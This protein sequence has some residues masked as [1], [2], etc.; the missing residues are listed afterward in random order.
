WLVEGTQ[1][2]RPLQPQIHFENS[3][4]DGFTLRPATR[5][6]LQ[7][8]FTEAAQRF[9][10]GDTLF[11]Y[12]TDHGTK[13]ADDLTNNRITLWGEKEA[14]SVNEL[15]EMLARFDPQV[16]VVVLM[17]QCF[18][19]SFA[20][21]MDNGPRKK[22]PTGNICGFFSATADRQAYGCY[23]ENRDKDNVG[24]S[25]AFIEQLA[26]GLSLPEAHRNVLVTDQTPD[27]PLTTS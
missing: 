4:I 19:G 13:N 1:L 26:A 9:K 10:P 24:H 2:E 7:R 14:L 25:F 5:A 3:T 12:V 8:W 21:L 17:S 15:R 23:P 22:L 27:V 11:F 16:R 20:H 18:S 6:A